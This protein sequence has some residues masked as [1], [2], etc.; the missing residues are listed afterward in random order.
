MLDDK[1][2]LTTGEYTEWKSKKKNF[3]YILKY[4]PYENINLIKT[5]QIC[6]YGNLEDSSFLLGA[7]KI[8]CRI[9]K[10][11]I[12]KTKKIHLNINTDFGHSQSSE[13]YEELKESALIKCNCN[14]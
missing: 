12:L 8:L 5:I 13:R 11:C 7:I 14:H 6:T 3:D 1:L 4:S 9:K 10:S 2:N